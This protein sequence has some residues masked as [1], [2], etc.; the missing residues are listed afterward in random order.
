MP[1]PLSDQADARFVQTLI[2]TAG[3]GRVQ[4]DGGTVEE[5][6]TGD[7]VWIPRITSY[8]VCYTKLLR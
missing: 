2:V 6:R 7:V 8:N 1:A 5:I 3:C 4:R